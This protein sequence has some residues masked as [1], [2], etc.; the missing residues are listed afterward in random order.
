MSETVTGQVVINDPD[1]LHARP[2]VKLTKLAKSF[3]SDIA[4]KAGDDGEWINA[5]S[6]SAVM[7]L[8]ARH[9]AILHVRA[10]GEDARGGV[11]AL[12]DLIKQNMG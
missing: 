7:K 12:I 1:G 10:T 8:K 5:K 2:A 11:D 6:L 4:I 9:G 3:C